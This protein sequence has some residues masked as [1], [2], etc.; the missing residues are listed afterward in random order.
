M[1]DTKKHL[2]SVYGTL[3]KG[4]SNNHIIKDGEY[5]GSFESK[6]IFDM[7]SVGDGFPALKLGGQTSVTIEVF[8]VDDKTLKSIDELEGYRKDSRDTSMYDRLSIFTPY[9]EAYIYIYNMSILGL[10]K[11]KSGDWVE[12]ITT[13]PV[14]KLFAE[15]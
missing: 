13:L 10:K 4:Q 9:G 12:Y 6:P 8:K 15:A 14:T 3:R 7:Y 5:I 1:S 2:V 11:I